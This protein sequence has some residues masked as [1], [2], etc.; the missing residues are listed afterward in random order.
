MDQVRVPWPH[1]P[2]SQNSSTSYWPFPIIPNIDFETKGQDWEK[3]DWADDF[4]DEA[5]GALWKSLLSFGF[6]NVDFMSR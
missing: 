3:C 5:F 1:N 4:G 2:K 6:L